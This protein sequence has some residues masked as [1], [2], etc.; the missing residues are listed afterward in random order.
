[1]KKL[2]K[3]VLR[4]V[5]VLVVLLA[6]AVI[7]RNPIA[8][9]VAESQIRKL[10]G[11]EAQIGSLDIGLS[12]PTVTITDYK[13]VNPAEFGGKAFVNIPELHVEY[14]RSVLWKRKLHLKVVRFNQAEVNVVENNEGKTNIELVQS[15]VQGTSTSTTSTNKSTP[16]I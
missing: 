5:I 1:M 9:A 13:L 2:F 14:D 3:W 11:F 6:V 8:K 15:R 16:S 4:I 7:F 10:T 12:S